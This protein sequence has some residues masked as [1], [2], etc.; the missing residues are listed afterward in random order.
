MKTIAIIQANVNGG[1]EKGRFQIYIEG[2]A[3]RICKNARKRGELKITPRFLVKPS[4][5][6][7]L[8]CGDTDRL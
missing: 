6:Y 5:K 1:M 4:S 3:E 2:R 7:K 8:S